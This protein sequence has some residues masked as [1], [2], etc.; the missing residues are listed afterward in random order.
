MLLPEVLV[1]PVVEVQTVAPEM[2]VLREVQAQQEMLEPMEQ[3]LPLVIR[4]RPA[5]LAQLET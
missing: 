2:R 1:V 3:E 5:P 4:D